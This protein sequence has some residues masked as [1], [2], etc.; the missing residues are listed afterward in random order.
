MAFTPVRERGAL[1][2]LGHILQMSDPRYGAL[3]AEQA[4][5]YERQQGLAALAQQYPEL[6]PL[7]QL[8]DP[9]LV[10]KAYMAKTGMG[11][12]DP[13]SIR[14]WDRYNKMTPEQQAAYLQMK[15]ANPYNLSQDL[16]M[17]PD[18]IVRP[19]P[20]APEANEGLAAP[21]EVMKAREA[22]IQKSYNDTYDRV[23]AQTGNQDQAL[24]AAEAAAA[25]TADLYDRRM[26]GLANVSSATPLPAPADGGYGVP[27]GGPDMA[28]PSGVPRDE[29][30]RRN[31]EMA[32]G[33]LA[34]LNDPAYDPRYPVDPDAPAPGSGVAIT[35]PLLA[36]QTDSASA[37]ESPG[38]I[39][40]AA[41]AAAAEA[42][43]QVNPEGQKELVKGYAQ[44]VQKL[45]EDAINA[46]KLINLNQNALNIL[47]QG[48]IS[49]TAGDARLTFGRALKTMG[50]NGAEDESSNT[51]AYIA[52]RAAAVGEIIKQFG[53]GTGLSDAD[54]EYAQKAAG[55]NIV[56]NEDAIRRILEISD[57]Q[58]RWVIEQYNKEVSSIKEG[59]MFSAATRPIDTT[60]PDPTAQPAPGQTQTGGWSIRR[61]D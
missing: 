61:L 48:I 36:S 3:Y 60:Q 41:D 54:R 43:A 46:N 24:Q 58:N 8:G 55:G 2:K 50:F 22:A 34:A 12:F 29:Q 44:N 51:D 17:G 40:S 9:G 37:T 20:G 15:R 1:G 35:P 19:Q 6:A 49:G 25:Q 27:G 59:G 42:A 38:N 56:M 5:D 45:R 53:S 57:K 7:A 4:Q 28:S 10:G 14:E 52:Q 13:A 26:G 47:D 32:N 21:T 39:L 16:T 31:A 18:G 33:G 11:G 30:A 23:Y